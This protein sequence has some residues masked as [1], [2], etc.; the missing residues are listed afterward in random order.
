[1]QKQIN[2]IAS[3]LQLQVLAIDGKHYNTTEEMY[4]AYPIL[5]YDGL[6]RCK[7]WP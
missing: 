6:L 2:R 3:H 4:Y 7:R 1:M 5:P